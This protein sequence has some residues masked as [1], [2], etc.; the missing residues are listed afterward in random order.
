M[1][2]PK[3][4]Y[5][6]LLDSHR[7]LVKKARR[8]SEIKKSQNQKIKAQE[9]EIEFLRQTIAELGCSIFWKKDLN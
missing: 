5:E 6:D 9:H 1:T 3:I 7:L 4:R 8:L 2:V